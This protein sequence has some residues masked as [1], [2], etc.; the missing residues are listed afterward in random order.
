VTDDDLHP[1]T[2]SLDDVVRGLRGGSSAR[3]VAGVFA[4]WGEIVGP[5]IAAHARPVSLVD[6]RL[7]VEVDEP[8]WATQVR[9]AERQVVERA[10]ACC[11]PGVVTSVRVVVV[12]RYPR[13]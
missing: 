9:Y 13:A 8:G 10:A 3:A 6:G 11:G 2:E 12:G 7:I 1:L 5:Q 4:Q